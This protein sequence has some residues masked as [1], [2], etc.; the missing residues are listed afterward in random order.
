MFFQSVYKVQGVRCLYIVIFSCSILVCAI[1]AFHCIYLDQYL[2]ARMYNILLFHLY[3]MANKKYIQVKCYLLTWYKFKLKN[4]LN[5]V[6]IY[7][8][9]KGISIY[10]MIAK[11][12]CFLLPSS[13]I[14]ASKMH[15]KQ[16]SFPC[17][18]YPN[19]HV[20]CLPIIKTPNWE[21][22]KKQQYIT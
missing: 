19:L 20:V 4:Q 15:P 1:L 14:D 6:L 18:V 3:K 21:I 9:I 8:S 11:E 5:L 7:F 10:R 2:S 16:N 22:C 13:L 12:N 17:S